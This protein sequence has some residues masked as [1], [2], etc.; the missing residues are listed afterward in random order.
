MRVRA[1]KKRVKE[2]IFQIFYGIHGIPIILRKLWL[3]L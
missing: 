2:E 3:S 1:E